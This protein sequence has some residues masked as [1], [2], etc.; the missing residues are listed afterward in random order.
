M[1][2]KINLNNLRDKAYQCAKEHGWHESE[3]SNEHWFCLV[4]SEL[5]EAVEADRMGRHANVERYKTIT[6]NSL[7]CKGLNTMIPKEKGF[8][9]AYEETI[10]NSVEE[11]LADAC[12]R[13]LDFA[14]LDNYDFD[15]Y[16]FD[17]RLKVDYLSK[18][19]TESIY[20]IVHCVMNW[21]ICDVLNEIFSFCWSR[22]INIMWHI[23]QK[24][25]YNE[26]RPYKHGKL[27]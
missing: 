24:M 11:E 21:G 6:E 18:S 25:K 20:I 16:D 15:D 3:K 10:K 17:D 8:I 14:G 27:Y 13:L 9:V 12:I 22:G 1:T 23:E 5:M 19:F 2:N 4:I 7:I 26:L